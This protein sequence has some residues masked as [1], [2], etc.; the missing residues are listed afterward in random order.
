MRR[1]VNDSQ[2]HYKHMKKSILS[3][4]RITIGEFL[5]ILFALFE[6]ENVN[7]KVTR[8][9]ALNIEN[10][11]KTKPYLKKRAITLKL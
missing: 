6:N 10:V 4:R 1:T 11:F 3:R 5:F 9:N 8:T 2:Y 7:K